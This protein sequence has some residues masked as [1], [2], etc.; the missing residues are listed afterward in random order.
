[1][2]DNVNLLIGII[3]FF[4]GFITKFFKTGLLI[5]GYNTASEEEKAKYDKEKLTKFAG[6]MLMVSSAIPLIGG[7]IIGKINI[8]PFYVVNIPWVIIIIG[9]VIY[10]NT[11]GRFKK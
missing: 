6:N 3:L 7:L 4:M 5:S 9:G 1:M 10:M 8:I 11:G 2:L